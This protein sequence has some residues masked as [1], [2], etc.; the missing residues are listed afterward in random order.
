MVCQQM[1]NYLQIPSLFS[2]VH[3]ANTAA[4]ELNDLVKINR[5]VYQ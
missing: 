1:Q 2:L 4:K 3:N 5:W